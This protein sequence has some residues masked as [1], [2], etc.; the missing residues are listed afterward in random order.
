MPNIKAK[1][2]RTRVGIIESAH[3]LFKTKGFENTS[4][5]EIVKSAGVCKK[6]YFN[7]F[8]SKEQLLL[9]IATHWYQSNVGTPQQTPPETPALA[10]L[11][12]NFLERIQY[13]PEHRSFM[14]LILKNSHGLNIEQAILRPEHDPKDAN[15]LEA[16]TLFRKAHTAG[17]LKDDVSPEYAY[18]AFI[19]LR[20]LVIRSWLQTPDMPIE[21]L[22]KHAEGMLAILFNG[23][24]KHGDIAQQ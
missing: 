6:T 12:K 23:C 21:Q 9:E 10:T 1:K 11:R 4:V 2:Q 8:D 3:A 20:N 14:E 7:Y 13:L 5:E 24:A 15:L 18:Q 19:T 17:E 22:K 16:L